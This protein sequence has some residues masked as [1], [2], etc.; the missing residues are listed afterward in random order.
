MSRTG[1]RRARYQTRPMPPGGGRPT[2]TYPRASQVRR[3]G[4]FTPALAQPYY[5]L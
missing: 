1:R 3:H 5:L 2:P 4:V